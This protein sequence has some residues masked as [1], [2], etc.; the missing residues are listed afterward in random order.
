M[1]IQ[2]FKMFCV[3]EILGFCMGDGR[4]ETQSPMQ[5]TVLAA[6]SVLDSH[7]D[8]FTMTTELVSRTG[9]VV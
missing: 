2:F 6:D 8:R 7:S 9:S 3:W 5:S 4:W 1:K